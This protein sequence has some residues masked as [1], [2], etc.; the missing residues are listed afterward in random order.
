MGGSD[1]VLKILIC[2][3][4]SF[5][6]QKLCGLV[7]DHFTRQ[8]IAVQIDCYTNEQDFLCA[9]LTEYTVAFLDIHLPDPD[10]LAL[11][12]KLREVNP[13]VILIFVTGFIEHGP[14]GYPLSVFRYVLKEDLEKQLPEC[15]QALSQKLYASPQFF[16]FRTT[17][18]ETNA[19]AY[20]DLCYFESIGHHVVLHVK[21]TQESYDLYTS[22]SSLE[23]RLPSRDFMRIQ[24]SYIVN[25]RN[26]QKVKGIELTMADGA[27]LTCKR[28]KAKEILRYFM[29]L[30][31]HPS[32]EEGLF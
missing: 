25:M 14:Q 12:Q 23:P 31:G 26:V 3:D 6:A 20:S 10:G 21:A 15:L 32:A 8:N 29:K 17:N 28:D 27:V 13:E 30:Q 1:F 24:R 22:L 7:K 5:F 11:A 2:D 19:C 18:G 16:V 9:P 4:E